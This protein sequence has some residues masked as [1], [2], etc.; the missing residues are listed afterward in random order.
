MRPTI[1]PIELEELSAAV[2]KTGIVVVVVDVVVVVFV[3]VDVVV[4]V[5]EVVVVDI[6]VV[7]VVNV[8]VD[9]TVVIAKTAKS[10]KDWLTTCSV[11]LRV[12]LG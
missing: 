1:K 4:V 11:A 8:S 5:V 9:V 7:V 2:S 6:V 3:V 12:L 10:N